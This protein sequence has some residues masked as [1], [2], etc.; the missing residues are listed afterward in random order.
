MSGPD[1]P[2]TATVR[3]ANE[4]FQISSTFRNTIVLA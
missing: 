1:Q 4:P 2:R 3:C